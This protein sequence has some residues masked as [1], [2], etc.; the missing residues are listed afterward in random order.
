MRLNSYC[1]LDHHCLP[2]GPSV[3]SASWPLP[4]HICCILRLSPIKEKKMSL[5]ATQPS[6]IFLAW[7]KKSKPLTVAFW[8][9][10][11]WSLHTVHAQVVS[12]S[13]SFTTVEAYRIFQFQKFQ[14][15]SCIRLWHMPLYCKLNTISSN[16]D[17]VLF[18]VKLWNEY[19]LRLERPTPAGVSVL[20]LRIFHKDLELNQKPHVSLAMRIR[21]L[22]Y[23][24]LRFTRITSVIVHIHYL[25]LSR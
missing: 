15:F 3:Q 21:E 22:S 19:L 23:R 4:F 9:F 17:S 1:G 7:G 8:L 25:F 24:C 18:I 11:F 20:S 16:L 10:M 5:M 6:V 12:F 13:T 2:P 14:I